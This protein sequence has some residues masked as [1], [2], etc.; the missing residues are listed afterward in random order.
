[1]HRFFD[2]SPVSPS[3]RYIALF[4]I[5][6]EDHTPNPGD[7]GDAVPIRYINA[8]TGVEQVIDSVFVSMFE[9]DLRIDAHPAWD[10][11]GRFVVYNGTEN[12]TRTVFMA[13]LK[14]IIIE[15]FPEFK[16]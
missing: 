3:G 10:R 8:K 12:G 9:K 5:P 13:D 1:M 7:L 11:S 14:D 6:F 15:Q 4:R 16:L 2:T